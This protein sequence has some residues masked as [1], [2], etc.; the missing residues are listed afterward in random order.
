V[1][2]GAATVVDDCAVVVDASMLEDVVSRATAD[3]L[4]PAS[5]THA[6]AGRSR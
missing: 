2:L 4:Q 3:A 5:A 1:V 6:S